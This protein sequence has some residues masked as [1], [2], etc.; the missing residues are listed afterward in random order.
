[1]FIHGKTNKIYYSVREKIKYYNDIISGKKVLHPK[2]N[3][4]QNSV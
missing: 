3:E 2:L 4:K 1:M